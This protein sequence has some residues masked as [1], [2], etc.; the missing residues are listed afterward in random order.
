MATNRTRLLAE[1]ALTLALAAVLARIVVYQL[2]QGGSVSLEML[3]LVVFSVRRGLPWGLLA[4]AL[5]G[6]L[7]YLVMQVGIVHWAQAL[8]D[9]PVAFGLVGLSGLASPAW[10]RW[11]ASRPAAALGAVAAATT[12]A[13]AARFFAHFMSGIVFF[14]QYAG[15]QP[16]WL[17][18]L[19]YNG[20]YML[21][22]AVLVIAGAALVLPAV[23]RV[24]PSDRT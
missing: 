3:P 2:P 12:L 17:Y 14:S 16:V 9:Y 6:P 19:L 23:E 7:D 4:C 13:V 15:D 24:V 20:S 8:L 21:P 22:S 5:F 1:M 10:H 11:H 18:S